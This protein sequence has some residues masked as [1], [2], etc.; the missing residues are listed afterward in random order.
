M[1]WSE[2]TPDQSWDDMQTARGAHFLQQRAWA[3]FQA[4]QGKKTFY[5]VGPSYSW[6]A[7]LEP[8]RFGTRLYCP[9]GP[10]AESA[11]AL[12]EALDS[13]KRCARAN[14][15]MFV[16]I[17]PQG[18]FDDDS[19]HALKLHKTP[20]DIQ[21]RFTLVSDV[22]RDDDTLYKDMSSTNRRLYRQAEQRGF[23]FAESVDP[24]DI[25]I[26]LDMIHDV[27][28]RS[29]IQ[30]HQDRYFK[31]MGRSVIWAGGRPP[32]HGTARWQTSC[33]LH[34]LR[35]RQYYLLRPRRHCR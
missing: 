12:T 1:Q 3:A 2:G 24:D 21:P 22:T 29:H 16:R 31:K 35:R 18:P 4:A 11:Q 5:M 25:S 33:D 10:T 28:A 32:G 15:A 13:L 7:I 27:A 20:R 8:S 9:L 19:L 17:E 34:Y 14:N 26:F 23:S 6:L 30:V